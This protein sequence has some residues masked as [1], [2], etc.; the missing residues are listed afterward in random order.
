MLVLSL[1]HRLKFGLIT[2]SC[3]SFTPSLA[4]ARTHRLS[5]VVE[6]YVRGLKKRIIS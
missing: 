2:H 5:L 1:T 4:L 6:I 3:E